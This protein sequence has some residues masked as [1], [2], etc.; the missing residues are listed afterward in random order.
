MP[1]FLDDIIATKKE[2][3]RALRSRKS[4]F[5]GRRSALRPFVKAI[6]SAAGGKAIIAEVKK[7]SPSKGDIVIDFDPVAIARNYEKGNAT[8][9]S[10]LTDERYFKGSLTYLE[11]VREAIS[12]PTL[13][14]DFIIDTLQVE[15]TAA[16]N[17]DAMLLIAAILGNDQMRE[18]YSAALELS[19]EPLIEVHTIRECERVLNLI[20]HPRIIGVNNRDLHTFAT[21]IRVSIEI[22]KIIPKD[23]V[24]IAESGIHDAQQATTLFA[25]GMRGILIGESLMRSADAAEFI[26]E[27]TNG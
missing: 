22:V 3:V 16:I 14:K 1:D 27:L 12:L 5:S 21:D 25:A 7:A 2:E 18:L 9:V 26:K 17:A 20:S 15:Q 13:R 8:A 24:V 11:S 23:I 10:V 4:G 6:A 19:V